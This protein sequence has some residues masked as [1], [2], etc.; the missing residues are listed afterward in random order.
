MATASVTDLL[1]RSPR[2]DDVSFCREP[3]DATTL[4]RLQM[5]LDDAK[6]LA[7][8]PNAKPATRTAVKRA[9]EA[10][11]KFLTGVDTIRF[12]LRSIGADVA[13]QMIRD[14][15]P[16]DAQIEEHEA[17]R[18]IENEQLIATGSRE[19]VPQL[20]WNPDTFPPAL[21]AASVE[22]IVVTGDGGREIDG[23]EVTAEVVAKVLS[24][25]SWSLAD[26]QTLL[27]ICQQLNQASSGI[28]RDLVARM[29]E[30]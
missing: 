14:H 2:S 15:P 23:S 9:E 28:Q 29:G 27:M 21:I 13:E 20:Q 10:I 3:D 8:R 22:R 6:R 1:T 11:D 24:G 12:Y 30:G 17:N 4:N 18:K 19:R 25:P 5:E 7:A 16:T 26:K